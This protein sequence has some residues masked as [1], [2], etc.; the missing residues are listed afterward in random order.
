MKDITNKL[1]T[2]LEAKRHLWNT[3]FLPAFSSLRECSPLDEYEEI[4]RLLFSALVL[5]DINKNLELE[6]DFNFGATPFPYLIVVPEEG[7]S[8]MDILVC[9]SSSGKW[10]FV[11]L[12]LNKNIQ[13]S[14]IEFFEWDRYSYTTYPYFRVKIEKCDIRQ[15]IVGWDALIE[16]KNARVFFVEE[17]S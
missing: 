17:K 14:F 8:K 12:S 13:F 10:E 1:F 7:I 11:N 2:Y 5:K 9:P 3:Y 4:D 16:T 15:D 6:S